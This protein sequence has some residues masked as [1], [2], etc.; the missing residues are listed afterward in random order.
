[1]LDLT[2]ETLESHGFKYARIDGQ[3]PLKKR[4]DEIDRF[5]KNDECT[6]MLGSIGSAGEG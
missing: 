5:R 2:Q 4:S 6:I 3:T 1:M